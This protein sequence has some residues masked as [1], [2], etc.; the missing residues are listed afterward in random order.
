V[1]EVRARPREDGVF[2]DLPAGAVLAEPIE[3]GGFYVG[4][5]VRAQPRLRVGR[6]SASCIK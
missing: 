1:I 6:N 3:N 2:V 4:I 5:T